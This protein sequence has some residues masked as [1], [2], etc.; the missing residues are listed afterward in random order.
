MDLPRQDS[1][2]WSPLIRQLAAA[3]NALLVPAWAYSGARVTRYYSELLE[4]HGF[5]PQ[6][7]AERAE[8]K[9]REFYQHLLGGVALPQG[10]SVLDV[11]CGMGDL[12]TFLHAQHMAPGA[13]L[14][15]DLVPGFVERCRAIHP[16]PYRFE[17][18]NF[19][20]RR[21]APHERYD[22]VVSMG[23]MVSR[24]I[25]YPAYVAACVEKMLGLADRSVVFNLITEVDRS[26]GNYQYA[27]KVGAITFLPRPQLQRIVA[28]AARAYGADFTI[29]ERRIYSD[30]TDAFVR[31]V[32]P[33]AR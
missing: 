9:D 6:A 21:F 5:A 30:A 22:L 26:M 7:L 31:I 3:R 32:K 28:A 23:V 29:D 4:T 8:D 18:A 2:R 24:V 14:G 20:T 25:A 19:I 33:P 16:P 15:I 10:A 13:Y 12:L 17:Q 27:H 1:T 11:G